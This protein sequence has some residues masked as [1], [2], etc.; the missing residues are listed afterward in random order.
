MR[1]IL[2]LATVF[3]L[4]S[5]FALGAET[6]SG[7]SSSSKP[8]APGTRQAETAS[9]QK[10]EPAKEPTKEPAKETTPSKEGVKARRPV[11]DKSQS[12][13]KAGL[14]EDE[15]FTAARKAASEDPKVSELRAKT[16]SAKND[17]VANKAMRAYL[18]ALYAKMR[19]IDPS[20]EERIDMTETAALRAL[21]Q[22]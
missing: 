15:R 6:G 1:R 7:G 4:P 12:G 8:A 18:R 17:Q 10:K 22:Q 20:L 5:V 21:P 3:L 16:D 14:S 11:K 9:P 13:D 19:S 2:P